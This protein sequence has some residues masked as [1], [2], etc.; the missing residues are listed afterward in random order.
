MDHL[1][2]QREGEYF[3]LAYKSKNGCDHYL[4]PNKCLYDQLPKT[5]HNQQKPALR[6]R[7]R[8]YPPDPQ[9]LKEESA[10]H[11]LYLQMR[12][13]MLS[14]SLGTVHPKNDQFNIIS[15][16]DATDEASAE[17]AAYAAQ[18][19]LGDY[20]S[21]KEDDYSQIKLLPRVMPNT[22]TDEV[23]NCHRQLVALSQQE[24]EQR[25]LWRVRKLARYGEQRFRLQ[26]TTTSGKEGE[27]VL[28]ARGIEIKQCSGG[29]GEQESQVYMGCNIVWV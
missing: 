13:D 14:G 27:A 29:H 21:I 25:F 3:G 9:R 10:R 8:F 23:A 7:V 17:L 26:P 1:R 12:A 2:L 4:D 19:E 11:W 22:W 20:G 16:L 24:S 15:V 18:A 5:S 28:S 6:F